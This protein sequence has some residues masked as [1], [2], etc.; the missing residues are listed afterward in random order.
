MFAKLQNHH[1]FQLKF[2]FEMLSFFQKFTVRGGGK[3]EYHEIDDWITLKLFRFMI[4]FTRLN[5]IQFELYGSPEGE[6]T[7]AF[8]K[9]FLFVMFNI[10]FI[11]FIFRHYIK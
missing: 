8:F 1:A 4:L 5:C 11:F 6:H 2:F 10:F 3:I 9:F 7:H